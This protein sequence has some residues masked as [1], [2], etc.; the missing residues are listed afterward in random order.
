MSRIGLR[1]GVS[2][3]G[4][5]ITSL[6]EIGGRR[7][8]RAPPL[9]APKGAVG[10]HLIANLGDHEAAP[11]L[12]VHRINPALSQPRHLQGGKPIEIGPGQILRPAVRRDW[13]ASL[14]SQSRP[15]SW[16]NCL[17]WSLCLRRSADARVNSVPLLT[18]KDGIASPASLIGYQAGV[19]AHGSPS[20]TRSPQAE[21]P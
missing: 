12:Q 4:S 20:R 5:N 11:S 6:T 3:L 21:L 19:M 7:R 18:P 14:R 1:R 15:T 17:V 8:G 13:T 9:S 10:T 16:P 2:S